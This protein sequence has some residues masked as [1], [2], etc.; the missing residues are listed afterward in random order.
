MLFCCKITFATIYALL[1]R[2]IFCRD[3]RTFVWR[4]NYQKNACMW[5]KNDKY[6][7]CTFELTLTRYSFQHYIQNSFLQI[8][9]W[10]IA[11]RRF[12][13]NFRSH[14]RSFPPLG[15]PPPLAAT[16]RVALKYCSP[17]NFRRACQRKFELRRRKLKKCNL[18][19][20]YEEICE[21]L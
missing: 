20:N 16:L 19:R 12:Y 7:V 15:S 6:Q 1:S 8:I 2:N 10:E 4:K 14:R 5:R 9:D 21:K 13:V 11:R 3:L 18:V 17:A